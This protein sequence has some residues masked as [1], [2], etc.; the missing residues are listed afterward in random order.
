METSLQLE[1]VSDGQARFMDIQKESIDSENQR[2]K[3]NPLDYPI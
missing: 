2:I 1:Q 3:L